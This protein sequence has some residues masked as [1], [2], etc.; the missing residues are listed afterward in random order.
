MFFWKRYISFYHFRNISE[1]LSKFWPKNFGRLVK[2]A[3]WVSRCTF[4]GKTVFEK[5]LRY[6][7]LMIVFGLRAI[8]LTTLTKKFEYRCPNCILSVPW[9]GLSKKIF[10][11]KSLFWFIFVILVT[12][13]GLLAK[14]PQ[15]G[16]HK[17]FLGIQRNV[18]GKKSL[19]KI[20]FFSYLGR[21]IFRLLGKNSSSGLSKMNI[22]CPEEQLWIYFGEVT[23]FFITCGIWVKNCQ[24][25]G[26]K[27]SAGLSKMQSD[28]PGDH[29]EKE[30]LFWKEYLF[31]L[32]IFGLRAMFFKTFTRIFHH[33]CPNCISRVQWKGLS[34]ISFPEKVYSD[35]F[36]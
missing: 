29:F 36:S 20:N 15:R 10:S 12:S 16:R 34:K 32:I 2:N 22:T 26:R 3:I 24:F 35:S 6:M 17:G 25:F 21:K 18:L 13:L 5:N 30:L 7:F 28:S 19:K 11:W 8:F 31:F 23:H 9:K 4:R 1:E 33:G 14:K 27:I